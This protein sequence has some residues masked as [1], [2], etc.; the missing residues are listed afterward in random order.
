MKMITN[1]RLSHC[2]ELNSTS[3]KPKS[4][5]AE[6]MISW[7]N[8][9]LTAVK[10]SSFFCFGSWK[11]RMLSNLYFKYWKTRGRFLKSW[12]GFQKLYIKINWFSYNFQG[13]IFVA[14]HQSWIKMNENLLN[15]WLISDALVVLCVVCTLWSYLL[16]LFFLHLFIQH[17]LSNNLRKSRHRWH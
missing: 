6:K 17:N 2:T 7:E 10:H 13:S 5:A 16:L 1:F 15:R 14:E 3:A 9:T 12:N 4:L 8:D 11:I